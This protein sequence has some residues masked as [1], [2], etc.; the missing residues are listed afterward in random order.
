MCVD[1]GAILALLKLE[2][3]NSSLVVHW[4]V[5]VCGFNDGVVCVGNGEV[6]T[7]RRDRS[8]PVVM[9]VPSLD[10]CEAM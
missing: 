1:I 10:R 7:G 4:G 6:C 2:D 8:L 9:T 5:L 3:M